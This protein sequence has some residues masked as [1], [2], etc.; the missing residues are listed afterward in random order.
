MWLRI[1][2]NDDKVMMMMMAKAKLF[3]LIASID[4][5]FVV[6]F[7]F[8]FHISSYLTMTLLVTH[9]YFSIFSCYYKREEER[10]S[11]E[12]KL[13]Y[14]K[15]KKQ[16]IILGSRFHFNIT[17]RRL[18]AFLT[19]FYFYNFILL[20]LTVVSWNVSFQHSTNCNIV[21]S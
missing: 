8:A 1:D 3:I 15:K 19:L 5:F 10:Q 18:N 20:K 7:Y 13:Q 11:S 2:S 17:G 6:S 14:S 12:I 21:V 9:S 16:K 4:V